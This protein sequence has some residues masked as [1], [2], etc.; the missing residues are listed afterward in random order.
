MTISARILKD[1]Q[2]YVAALRGTVTMSDVVE[3]IRQNADNPDFNPVMDRL[4]FL[5]HGLDLSDADF[6]TVFAMKDELVERYFGGTL[7]DTNGSPLFRV[8]LLARPTP[9]EGI[10]SLFRAVMESENAI[11]VARC[12]RDLGEALQWLG[13]ENLASETFQE[14]LVRL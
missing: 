4:I 10:M 14:E 2:L 13:R 6:S 7:P 8:A 1:T 12:F 9:N 3:T 5:H 11:I